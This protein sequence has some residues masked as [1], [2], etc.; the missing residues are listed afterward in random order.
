MLINAGRRFVK[1]GGKCGEFSFLMSKR[2]FVT[3]ILSNFA[4]GYCASVGFRRKP[5][6]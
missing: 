4:V 5:I 2:V 1:S 6:L 3:E